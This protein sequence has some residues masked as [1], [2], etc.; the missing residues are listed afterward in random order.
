[1]D[2]GQ[3][4]QQNLLSPMVLCFALGAVAG[5]LKSDLRL[6]QD[7]YVALSAY[8][9]LAIGLKGGVALSQT[10][11]AVLAGPLLATLF[12]SVVTPL[13][14]FGAARL[15]L[16]LG[17]PDCAAMAAHYGSVS[18]VTFIACQA[19]L[20]N[21]HEPF[22]GYLPALVAVLEIPAIV[23]ALLLASRGTKRRGAG[24]KATLHEILTGKSIVLLAGGM[25]VG[26]LSGDAGFKKV[27]A[28]FVDPFQGVLCL[29]LLEMGL[30]AA[31]RL[32][33]LRRVGWRLVVYGTVIPVIHGTLG[34]GAGLISGMGVGSATVLGTMAAS[35]S[36]IAAPAAV[37]M[38]L[39]EANPSYYLTAAVG[40]TFPFNLALGIPL[41][42]S[43]A[44][45]LGAP[46]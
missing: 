28:F 18:A 29:F 25:V 2:I 41:Y 3:L 38:A 27:T 6:P 14:A 21:A 9:L 11:L 39:P 26:A 37:R 32:G 15:T 8:L 40:I 1:M 43:V 46:G 31:E 16:R 17:V 23:V 34:V 13:F 44:V 19:F 5:L 12:L 33:D 7:V 35:A 10:S 30:I 22:D 20:M 4:L 36:Y 24:L 45:W 42:Y